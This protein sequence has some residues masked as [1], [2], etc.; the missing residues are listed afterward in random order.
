MEATISFPRGLTELVEFR[1]LCLHVGGRHNALATVWHLFAH[2]AHSAQV[3]AVGF[4]PDRDVDL[5]RAEFADKAEWVALQESGWVTRTGDGGWLCERFARLNQ[6]LDPAHR[7][8]AARGGVMNRFD[9][10]LKKTEANS[11]SQLTLLPAECFRVEGRALSS[12]EIQRVQMLVVAM[13]GVTNRAD[14]KSHEGDWPS[15]LVAHA[16]AVLG[17]YGPGVAMNVCRELVRLGFDAAGR[18]ANPAVPSTTELC[19][20]RFDQLVALLKAHPENR[21]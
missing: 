16:H 15:D 4:I 14:R 12:E 18:R 20:R 5:L 10:K 6:H 9:Q 11:L 17:K 1:R 7:T 2:L 8:M 3:G 13:D 19:L 21:L